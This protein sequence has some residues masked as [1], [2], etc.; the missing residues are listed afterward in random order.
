MTLLTNLRHP[1]PMIS[2]A[3]LA[4]GLMLALPAW[5]ED[6]VVLIMETSKGDMTLAL[7]SEAA[8]ETVENFLH[9]VDAGF[10]DGLT[11]HRV[12]PGF[13]IQGGGFNP[14]MTQAETRAP[15]QNESDNGLS[16]ERGT[17]AMA[18][19]QSPHSATSQFFINLSDNQ[20]LDHQ[21]NRWGY[22]VFGEVTSGMEV[23]DAIVEVPRG[24]QSTAQGNFADVPE[25]PVIIHQIRRH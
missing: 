24:R 2:R 23:A 4:L 8:P 6:R 13:M 9:Y 12:I 11:F 25:T 10:Y 16:N 21:G 7:N 5:A 19:T 17:L 14:D 15:I 1:L 20:R 18:R 3:A 22:A